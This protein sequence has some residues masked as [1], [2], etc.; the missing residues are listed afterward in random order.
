MARK[1]L[2]FQTFQWETPTAENHWS[3]R[4]IN[5]IAANLMAVFAANVR[6]TVSG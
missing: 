3:K 2:T 6:M 5:K 1:L 4:Y